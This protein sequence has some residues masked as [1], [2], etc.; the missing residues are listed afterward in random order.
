MKFTKIPF[1]D[2]NAQRVYENYINNLQATLKPLNNNQIEDVMM[3]FNSHIY[4][5][6]QH[7]KETPEL[8]NLLDAIDKLGPL[9]VV[10]KPLIADKLLDKATKSFN[11]ID[12]FKALILNFTNGVSYI[13][14]FVLYLS[15][16]SF[17]FLI[18]AKLFDNSVGL[19]YKKNEYAVLGI[20]SDLPASSELTG[21]WFIPIMLLAVIILYFLITLLLKFKKSLSKNQSK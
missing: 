20:G 10:L 19:Y 21:N 15:L 11:P 3:E 13:I 18:I 12:V 8:N 5:H 14:F 1:V 17:I 7:N 16:G 6:I 2:Q 4:E 9:Q